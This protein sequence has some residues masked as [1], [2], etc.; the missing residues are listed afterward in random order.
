MVKTSITGLK[1]QK[2]YID[3]MVNIFSLFYYSFKQEDCL[4]R[5]RLCLLK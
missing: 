4:R 1:L 5:L 2:K 3:Q